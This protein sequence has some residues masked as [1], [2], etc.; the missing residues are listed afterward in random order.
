[1][2]YFKALK[3]CKQNEIYAYFL[4]KAANIRDKK[5]K[6]KGKETTE[7]ALQGADDE[8]FTVLQSKYRL[9]L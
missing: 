6:V 2:E 7:P 4:Q 8:A 1:M 9:L 3:E 5:K